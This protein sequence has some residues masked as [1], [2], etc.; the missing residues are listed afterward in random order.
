M[1]KIIYICPRNLDAGTSLMAKIQSISNRI[2]PDNISAA[3]PKV[4]NHEGIV[5]GIFNPV[6]SVMVCDGSVLL[7]SAS[8]KNDWYIP[9]SGQLD[10]TYALFRGNAS[11]VEVLSDVVA[12]RTIWYY[13]D[14]SIFIASTSQMAITSIL[15]MFEFNQSVVPWMLSTGTLGPSGCWDR[16]LVRLDGESSVVLDRMNWQIKVNKNEVLFSAKDMTGRNAQEPLKQLIRDSVISLNLKHSDWVLPL[17]GGYDSRAILLC[18]LSDARI[19]Q[20]ITW[21]LGSSLDEKYNDARVAND[22]ANY[23]KLPHTYYETD[24]AEESIERIIN[25]FLVCGEGQVDHISGYMDGMKIWKTLYDNGVCGIIRGDEGF[26]WMPVANEMDTRLSLGMPLWSDYSNLRPLEEF[27]LP[28]HEIPF[29]YHRKTG[30]SLEGWRDRLYHQIRIPLVLAALNDIKSAYVEIVNPLLSKKIIYYVREMPDHLRTDKKIFKDIVRSWSP[31]IDYAKY[32]AVSTKENV[33]Q[34]K[35]VVDFLQQELSSAITDAIFPRE[36]IDYIR[37][38]I[39]TIEDNPNPSRHL[40][41]RKIIKSLIPKGLR[42]SVKNLAYTRPEMDFNTL[43]FRVYLISHM[44]KTFSSSL[45]KN[46]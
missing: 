38:G 41:F 25:R 1:S 12:S 35:P 23:F 22:L 42:S 7:G 45:E 4:L 30:E 14:D 8:E 9:F 44:N 27:G 2:L 19:M 32:A 39:D 37:A 10:G 31:K 18:L 17:S 3:A 11:H 46:K 16:R 15:G 20:T 24:L 6:G 5:V 26:G 43:A 28:K 34:S 36:F 40:G 21:G 13:F 33:L 29:V